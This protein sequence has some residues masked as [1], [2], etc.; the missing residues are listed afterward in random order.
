MLINCAMVTT[1]IT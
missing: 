1:G